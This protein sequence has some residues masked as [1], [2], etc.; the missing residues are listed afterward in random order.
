M[1]H[2]DD[3]ALMVHLARRV[4]FGANREELERQEAQGYEATV[5]EL[6]NPPEDRPAG[7]LLLLLRYMPDWLRPAATP[8]R[9]QS[10]WM[11]NMITTQRPLEEK[12]ALFWYQVFAT[13]NAKVD[14]SH[15]MLGQLVMFRRHGMGNYRDILMQLSQNP[16]MIYFLDNS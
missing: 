12:M 11:Y 7:N 14:N 2:K 1:S 8:T 13:G 4:G 15:Q 10:T 9:A 16:A 5:E 6:L 3:L